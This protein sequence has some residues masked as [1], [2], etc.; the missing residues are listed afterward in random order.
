[1]K[2]KLCLIIAF[3][4]L[5]FVEAS[6]AQ[7]CDN[8]IKKKPNKIRSAIKNKSD[9]NFNLY[10]GPIAGLGIYK[11]EAGASFGFSYKRYN[12]LIGATEK[13]QYYNLKSIRISSAIDRD[14]FYQLGWHGGFFIQTGL[15]NNTYFMLTPG[16]E[17]FDYFEKGNVFIMG[18][19]LRHGWPNIN[20][21]YLF[22]FKSF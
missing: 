3:I 19:G 10:V 4:C 13:N 22:R 16:F 8:F 2:Y 9:K 20:F 12:F 1:M 17:M 11:L 21:I 15:I 5:L 7:S 6:K 14:A 18:I